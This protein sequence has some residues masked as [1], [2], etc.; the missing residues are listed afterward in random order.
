LIDGDETQNQHRRRQ[1]HSRN[2]RP[3]PAEAVEQVVGPSQHK[4][5]R[6]NALA[7]QGLL[8]SRFQARKF[9]GV[10][11]EPPVEEL[12]DSVRGL[13]FVHSSTPL[14]L[15]AA[16]SACAA[17]EQWVLTLPSEQPMTAAVSATSNSSQ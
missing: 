16:A 11:I 14:A 6:V 5:G 7:R 9:A 12:P 13:L 3:G 15:K 8:A 17:R 2:D 10:Q 1:Q 4:G